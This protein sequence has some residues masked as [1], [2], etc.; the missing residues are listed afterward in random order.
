MR[1]IAL[2]I[3]VII[4]S[5]V[6]AVSIGVSNIVSTEISISN[7][8]RQSQMAFYAADAGVDCAIYWDTIHQGLS[9]SAFSTTTSGS[10]S[11]TSAC[12][13][14]KIIIGG[15]NSCVNSLDGSGSYSTCSGA[16]DKKAGKSIFTLSFSNGSCAIVTVI[17]KQ[18]PL[19]NPTALVASIHSDGYSSGA[20]VGF[21]GLATCN[22][23]SPRVFQRS[24][25]VTVYE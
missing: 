21:S 24:L 5:I 23:T 10:N 8:G 25:E 1:G 15:T 6:L 19:S 7:T 12:A 16:G 9:Q 3:S 18:D 17:K 13:G 20:G 22:S 2:L 11:L 4:V 14:D